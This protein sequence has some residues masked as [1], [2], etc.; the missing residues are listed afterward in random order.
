MVEVNMFYLN[1]DVWKGIIILLLL[2]IF[3]TFLFFKKSYKLSS[4]LILYIGILLLY[5]EVNFLIATITIAT[6]VIVAFTGNGT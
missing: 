6:S 3:A 1:L 5:N 2:I 4:L